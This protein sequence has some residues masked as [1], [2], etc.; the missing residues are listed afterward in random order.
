[1][2][3]SIRRIS[4]HVELFCNL[5]Y[6]FFLLYTYYWYVEQNSVRFFFEN[7]LHRRKEKKL[8]Q[9]NYWT[10]FQ[11][12]KNHNKLEY[13]IYNRLYASYGEIQK[14]G[15]F[16]FLGWSSRLICTNRLYITCNHETNCSPPHP[17]L[18]LPRS[19][20][21]NH[22]DSAAHRQWKERTTPTQRTPQNFQST[23]CRRPHQNKLMLLPRSHHSAGR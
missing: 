21:T 1:M 12:S 6:V 11:I 5:W 8:S 23:T 16:H 3:P 18:L 15:L 19:N 4:K 20:L 14:F 9:I 10:D 22:S 13:I 2:T 7:S 17:Q